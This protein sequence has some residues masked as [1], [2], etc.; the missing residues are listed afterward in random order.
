MVRRPSLLVIAGALTSGCVL[1]RAG[2][3]LVALFTHSSEIWLPRIVVAIWVV[4]I[5]FGLMLNLELV[6]IYACP[7][8]LLSLQLS[9]ESAL[10]LL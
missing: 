6:V 1:F 8:I 2:S 5:V 10:I 9:F 4:L 7:S 3:E